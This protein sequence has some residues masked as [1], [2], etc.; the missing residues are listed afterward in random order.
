[1]LCSGCGAEALFRAEPPAEPKR[2]EQSDRW[3]KHVLKMAETGDWLVV[4]G[5]K[6]VDDLVVEATRIPL[7]HA[8][9]LDKE[10]KEIT[11]AVGKGVRVRPL[12]GFVH[13]AHR[14][15]VIR[16][17]WW[18]PGRGR[19]ASEA[20]RAL[21]G[22]KYDFLGTVGMGSDDK[23]YCSELTFYVYRH[24]FMKEKLPRVVLPGV[25][26]LW[27]KIVLDTGWRDDPAEP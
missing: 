5:Y 12:R 21:V 11:E 27:G 7:S 22:S 16:P 2:S 17:K 13:K 18:T 26:Y 3:T 9:I 8:A 19:E 25:M 14:I 23:F 20:A 24:W 10:R 15:L 1:M 4:R 6:D